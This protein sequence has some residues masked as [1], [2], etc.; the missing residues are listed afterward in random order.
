MK[1]EQIAQ[2]EKI[3]RDILQ[4]QIRE[5]QPTNKN[6]LVILGATEK[7]LDNL[8]QQLI[9]CTQEE[10][11]VQIILS[12]LATKVID[13]DPIKSLFGEDKIIREQDITDI[14]SIV[15]SSSVILLPA[16]SYPMVGKIALRLVDTAC[17]YLVYHALCQGKQVL[18]TADDLIRKKN[19]SDK[20]LQL[21]DEIDEEHVNTLSG[22]GVIWV[23]EDRIIETILDADMSNKVFAQTPIIS[24]SV[25]D[26]LA[27]NVKELVYTEPTIITPLA[28]DHAQ[29]RGIKIIRKQ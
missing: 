28:R 19:Y 10:W 4:S 20:K 14:P 22:F 25:I 1:P 13:L 21:L 27:L 6:L 17:T 2:I 11:K 24:A 29:K 9:Q 3:V 7:P 23:T 16:F 12:E 15:E 26:N 5:T 8:F 18:A